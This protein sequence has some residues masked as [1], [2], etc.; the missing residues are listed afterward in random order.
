MAANKWNCPKEWKQRYILKGF[1]GHYCCCC[2]S[3]EFILYGRGRTRCLRAKAATICHRNYRENISLS[4]SIQWKWTDIRKLSPLKLVVHK[5]TD[6]I[7]PRSA[8]ARPSNAI[9]GALCSNW[10]STRTQFGAYW[11]RIKNIQE[12]PWFCWSCIV[13]LERV[14][15][16]YH[17]ALPMHSAPNTLSEDI[18]NWNGAYFGQKRCLHSLPNGR[19]MLLAC[20]LDCWTIMKYFV[21]CYVGGQALHLSLHIHWCMSQL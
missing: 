14:R 8:M 12:H 13:L 11:N 1:S 3:I 20:S 15:M 5:R 19:S 18:R 7:H 2:L 17:G 16:V 21:H 6:T 9:Y 4:L 10:V